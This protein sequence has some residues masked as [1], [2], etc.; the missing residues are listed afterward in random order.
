MTTPNRIWIWPE[1]S[2][3]GNINWLKGCFRTEP[4]RPLDDK[5]GPT[6][7]A[8]VPA[9]VAD[10]LL[11]AL[12]GALASL[13]HAD[14]ADGVCCCG[15]NMEGHSDPMSCGHAPVDMGDYYGSRAITA[16]RAA[17]AKARGQS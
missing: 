17:I 5:D 9:A 2:A 12:E 16:A 7:A 10:D 4:H 1:Q 13:E 14:L 8:Y 3:T 6:G 15:D 11:A